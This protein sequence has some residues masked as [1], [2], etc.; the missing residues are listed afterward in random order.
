MHSKKRTFKD[1]LLKQEDEAGFFSMKRDHIA[2][3][4]VKYT[5]EQIKQ[6]LVGLIFVTVILLLLVNDFGIKIMIIT[7]D[8]FILGAAAINIKIK[9]AQEM[10]RYVRERFDKSYGR[11]K[12]DKL[13]HTITGY[14]N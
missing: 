2:G 12:Y 10:E 1:W 9:K 11:G 13:V 8:V 5:Y 14:D 7:F 4:R 3:L 6:Y